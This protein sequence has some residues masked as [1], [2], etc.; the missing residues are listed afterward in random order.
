MKMQRIRWFELRIFGYCFAVLAIYAIPALGQPVPGALTTD[1]TNI[2]TANWNDSANWS[3]G[4]PNVINEDFGVINNGGTAQVNS[5]VAVQPG[6]VSLGTAGGE[7]GTLDIL[8]GGSLTVVDDAMTFPSDGSVRIGQGG[9]GHLFVR[10][11][12]TLNSL[13]L[14]LGIG[15][16]DSTLTLGGTA[17]GTAMVMTGSATLGR[18]TRVIGQSVNFS[19][20]GPLVLQPTSVLIP[21]IRAGTHS[22]LKT[23]GAATIAGTLRPE[24][25][26]IVP[27]PT[28]RWNIVDAAMINGS[29]TIDASA[30]PPLPPSQIYALYR[31]TGG[32]GTQL[33]LGVEQLLTLRVDWDS[34]SVSIVNSGTSAIALDSYSILSGLGGL[35]PAQ[36]VW[37]SLADQSVA[38]WQEANP[39]NV[40]LS[41]INPTGSLSI[42]GGTN[43][44]LGTPF[45]PVIP[46]QF[47]DSPEDIVFRYTKPTGETLNGYVEYVGLRDTNDFRLTID[48]ATGQGQLRNDGGISLALEGYSIFSDSGALLT[49]WNSLDDQNVDGSGTWQEA[50]PTT[51]TISELNPTASTTIAPNAGYALG[52]LWNTGGAQDLRLVYQLANED[53]TRTGTVIFGA[54]PPI[55][56]TGIQGDFN[57]SGG[58]E[59]ADLTLLLNNWAKAVPPTPAGWTGSPITAPAVDND[60]L[61]ALL[62]NWG[63]VA[64]FG[65]QSVAVPEPS[66][67]ASFAAAVASLV[68]CRRLR[69]HV[70]AH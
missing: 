22:A 8:S 44:A 38:G 4:V 28:G 49:G 7:T 35:N 20:T 62:N 16:V 50:L 39:R 65:S 47:G 11:G 46:A 45:T 32:N 52:A 42:N 56:G 29:M 24:F 60:E 17:A 41:E 21:E 27:T 51:T 48:P 31:A 5:V 43:R 70:R 37:T 55:S 61:T 58:V 59:N 9:T 23:T 69:T 57:S 3:A 12:G 40:A 26:G 6:G 1:W 30:A 67:L 14:M 25:V 66:T 10:P 36:G 64:G 19:A 33:Q 63:K 34:K 54:L 53:S 2:G 15:S 18:T 13:S 68:A